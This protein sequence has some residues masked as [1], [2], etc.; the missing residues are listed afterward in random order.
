MPTTNKLTNV[1]VKSAKAAL[2]RQR[3]LSDG[4]RLYLRARNRTGSIV[5]DW[6][7]IYTPRPGAAQRKLG[8]GSYPTV[9]LEKARQKADEARKYLADGIDPQ[10]ERSVQ[11][12][13]RASAEAL[14]QTVADL[15]K[16]WHALALS[17]RKDGGAEIKRAFDKDVLPKIG[18]VLLKNVRRGHA[19]A[20]L[21]E[22]LGRD[23][24]RLA[25]RL[26]SEMRQMFKFGVVRDLIPADPTY[27]I[28][29]NDVG[30][31]DTERERVLSEDEIRALKTLLPAAKLAK[32]TE[33]AVWI[34]LATCCRVGEISKARW[35]DIDLAQGTWI[36][37]ADNAKNKKPHTIFLSAFAAKQFENL[38]AICTSADWAYPNS[39]DDK[40][41]AEKV[42]P[43]HINLKAI[44]KQLRDRQRTE[45]LNKRS[46]A[47]T[48]LKLSGGDWVPH[49]LR[50]T[51]ATMMA[52]LGVMPAIIERCLNHVEQNRMTRVYQ[53]Y[54]FSAE[55][56]QAW[57]LLGQRLEIL[58][59]DYAT[60]VVTLGTRKQ[61]RGRYKSRS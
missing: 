2:G 7:F 16:S 14:P 1:A 35:S 38:R 55:Q 44:V 50:R 24:R 42:E 27:G 15:F 9:T 58:T 21:D 32:P 47:V 53:R 22:V 25:N 20:V 4:N 37:P 23:A 60:N 54:D 17:H 40:V 13:N 6:V 39:A 31:R 52:S 34:M 19:T 29:K 51:G 33:L 48:T 8:L 11:E 59:S 26:L 5:K 57:T 30:G 56:R 61:S 18:G 10:V 12:A 43:S 36:I 49:D 3:M 46:A 45:A 41:S 28:T